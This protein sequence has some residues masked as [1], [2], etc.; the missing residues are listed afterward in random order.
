MNA[1]AILNSTH[2]RAALVP[3]YARRPTTR[4][5]PVGCSLVGRATDKRLIGR[6]EAWAIDIGSM[7]IAFAKKGFQFRGGGRIK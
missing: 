7:T 1:R 5:V 4:P 3:A 6:A 2:D